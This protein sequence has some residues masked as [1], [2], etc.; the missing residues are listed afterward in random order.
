MC[1]SPCPFVNRVQLMEIES[2]Q[3]R[4]LRLPAD[5][6]IAGIRDVHKLISKSLVPR[7]SDYDSLDTIG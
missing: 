5:C 6:S 4:S 1:A 2:D 3:A 7:H